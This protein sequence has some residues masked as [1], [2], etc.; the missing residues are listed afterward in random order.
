MFKHNKD[1]TILLIWLMM[2]LLVGCN[3]KE[4]TNETKV[5]QKKSHPVSMSASIEEYSAMDQDERK[6]SCEN[7][8]IEI[9]GVVYR[10]GNSFKIV[11]ENRD[12]IVISCAFDNYTDE[13]TEISSGDYITISGLC[14]SSFDDSMYLYECQMTNI[15]KKI[16]TEE[17]E[18]L[19]NDNKYL[20]DSSLT[21]DRNL[22]NDYIKNDIADYNSNDE[23]AAEDN[24]TSYDNDLEY[25]NQELTNSN[26]DVYINNNVSEEN[27]EL[28][29][30]D[31]NNQQ[32]NTDINYSQG[33][34]AVNDKNG[35][36]HMVGECIATTGSGNQLMTQP[37]F[38]DTLEEAENY[39]A[40]YHPQ[41]EKRKCGN[42]WED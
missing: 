27:T 15:V 19:S 10:D 17:V 38:F 3:E 22:G 5:V 39:S 20:A 18:V 1:I 23:K 37:V 30:V 16:E 2:T 40:Q 24:V 26:T 33:R 41:Q 21:V 25:T 34:Y 7:N 11:N 4:S 28:E 35:K 9:S 32:N 13:M 42:C 12:G 6:E 8:Y 14:S 31:Y 36:I 29:G